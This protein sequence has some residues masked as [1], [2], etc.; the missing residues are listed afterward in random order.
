MKKLFIVLFVCAL[1]GIAFAAAPVNHTA[2]IAP[3]SSKIASGGFS[4]S[5]TN[6]SLEYTMGFNKS[7]LH[8][9]GYFTG[10]LSLEGIMQ[11]YI[12]NWNNID[13]GFSYG[14][15][16]RF[17]TG[18]G[19]LSGISMW[20]M[21]YVLAQNVSFYGGVKLTLDFG[22]NTWGFYFDQDIN[23]Y[24]GT[25]IDIVENLKFYIEMQPSVWSSPNNA[26]LGVNYYFPVK[27]EVVE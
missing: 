1:A 21:S 9:K 12:S 24:L 11:H 26:F 18:F 16:T 14:G 25:E 4:S 17:G 5:L 8:I 7:N 27:S 20:N 13:M 6:L 23:L 3:Q 10:S 19:E 22:I 2:V 15:G